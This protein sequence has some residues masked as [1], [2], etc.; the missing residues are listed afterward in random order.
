MNLLTD[1]TQSNDLFEL[2]MESRSGQRATK[3]LHIVLT[4]TKTTVAKLSKRVTGDEYNHVSIA[5]NDDY[6]SL[7][8]YAL[9]NNVNSSGGDF[10]VEDTSTWNGPKYK[11][12]TVSVTDDVYRRAISL[13]VEQ[14]LNAQETRYHHAGMLNAVFNKTFSKTATGRRMIC[15]EFVLWV[16]AESGAEL[17]DINGFSVKP[18][19]IAN[20]KLLTFYKE[21]EFVSNRK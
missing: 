7:Y 12:Y 11:A 6:K 19:D 21:G 10:K 4:D 5:F 13:V 1:I 14:A 20:S 2:F 8:T 15:S 18:N 16:L 9:S 3:K 17:K